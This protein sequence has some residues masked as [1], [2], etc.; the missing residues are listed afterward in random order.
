MP[1]H[2]SCSYT[3]I[4]GS[5]GR[6]VSSANAGGTFF[7]GAQPAAVHTFNKGATSTATSTAADSY[8]PSSDVHMSDEQHTYGEASHQPLQKVATKPPLR[9]QFVEEVD[10]LEIPNIRELPKSHLAEIYMTKEEMSKIHGEAWE[11]VELMNLG[12]EYDE[13]D[14]FSKR[15]LV[16]LKDDCIERRKRMRERAYKV[17]FGAQAFR[18]QRLQEMNGSSPYSSPVHFPEH[19][20]AS[21]QIMADLYHQVS[22][23]AQ[24]VARQV[25]MWDA[26]AAAEPAY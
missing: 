12:I 4:L 10:I 14:S 9:V 18:M 8:P 6:P 17:V 25:A 5:W 13:Q 11:I 1:P 16:D 19:S 3:D 7:C 22:A 21:T 23:P 24:G 2:S 20:L 26:M 15:G